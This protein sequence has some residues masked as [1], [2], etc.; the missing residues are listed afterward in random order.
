MDFQPKDQSFVF[1]GVEAI[2][3]AQLETFPYAYPHREAEFTISTDEFTAVCPFSGLPDF[4][5]ATIDYV[6][7]DRCVELRS[8]KYYLHS[9]RNVG[10]WYEH[11]VNRILEDLA[12]AVRPKRMTI[13]LDYNVRGGLKSVARASYDASKDELPERSPEHSDSRGAVAPPPLPPAAPAADEG[14]PFEESPE[15][16]EENGGEAVPSEEEWI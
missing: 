9:Y 3:A 12:R 1:Q 13:T 15:A 16:D 6:P 11:A 10:I 7:T 5:R 8:L 4:G 2:D 14:N